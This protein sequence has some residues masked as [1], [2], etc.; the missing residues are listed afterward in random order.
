[1]AAAVAAGWQLPWRGLVA[2][3][4]EL[5]AEW[6][7]QDVR[8]ALCQLLLVWLSLNL[9][10]I[11]LAWR[12]YGEEVATLCYRT[13]PAGRRSPGTGPGPTRPRAHS[14]SPAS[15]ARRNGA[16]ERHCP[17]R[18]GSTAELAKTHRE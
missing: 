6:A 5:A 1:M 2:L 13:G 8:A 16:A 17:P 10:G 15:P 14:L 18:E 12:V 9:L 7:A 11:H 3:G 4:R